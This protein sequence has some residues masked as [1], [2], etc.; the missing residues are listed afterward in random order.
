MEHD[1]H[2][3]YPR[4]CA[5]DGGGLKRRVRDFWN[6]NPCGVVYAGGESRRAYYDGQARTRYEL[7]PYIRAFARFEEGHDKDVLEVG[8]GMGADH[9]EWANARPRSLTG[10]DLTLMAVEHT[11]ERFELQGFTPCVFVADAEW[12]PFRDA[13]FDIVYSWGV[14]HHSPDTAKGVEE[15]SRVLRPGGRARIM[16]YHKRSITGLLLW[17]RYGLMA[18]R[19]FRSWSEIYSHHLESPGTKAFTVEEARRMF[20]RFRHVEISLRLSIGDLL[21]GAAGQRHGGEFLRL[22]RGLWPRWLMRRFCRR[23]GLCMLIEAVK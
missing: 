15:V 22:M 18:G 23:F 11:K 7:E 20:S 6:E 9:L 21:E 3:I 4:G 17:L 10:I 5:M 16:L 1:T 14:L 12:L 8:I 19:P 13:S 2:A